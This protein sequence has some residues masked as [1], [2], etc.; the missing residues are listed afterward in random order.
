MATT[1]KQI[2]GAEAIQ[3]IQSRVQIT[4]PGK[5]TLQVVSSNPYENRIILGL[6]AQSIEGLAKAKEFL[7][8]GNFK[9]AA[10]TNM[11]TSVYNDSSFIPSK[12][13][14]VT[15][16]VDY[17][18]NRKGEMILGVTS[19]SEIKAKVTKKVNLGDEFANLLDVAN[20]VSSDE[21]QLD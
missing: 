2:T 5:Y 14:Y 20:E 15:C 13:E 6:K 19:V 9:D 16:M 7:R 11:S 18:E 1:A 8:E 12:G 17:V 21:P 10:N 4:E 3:Y